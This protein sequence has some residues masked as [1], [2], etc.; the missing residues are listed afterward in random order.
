LNCATLHEGDALLYRKFLDELPCP[1]YLVTI[2][3]PGK[4]AFAHR[5]FERWKDLVGAILDIHGSY[6]GE[7]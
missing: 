6:T 5:P 7:A 3:E 4:V 2:N 1:R